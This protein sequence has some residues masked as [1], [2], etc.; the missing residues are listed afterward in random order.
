MFCSGNEAETPL[1]AG[2][3][4]KESKQYAGR[5]YYYNTGT[6]ET[7]WER[8]CAFDPNQM[9]RIEITYDRKFGKFDPQKLCA[10]LLAV[11]SD[12][13]SAVGVAGMIAKDGK[14]VIKGPM[15]QA[16]KLVKPL[17]S[18]PSLTVVCTPPIPDAAMGIAPAPAPRPAPAPAPA[19]APPPLPAPPPAPVPGPAP[20]PVEQPAAPAEGGFGFAA[21]A[22]AAAGGMEMPMPPMDAMPDFGNMDSM[23]MDFMA[24]MDAMN[25]PQAVE[26]DAS[27]IAPSPR[28]ASP[29][30]DMSADGDTP[31]SG[32]RRGGKKKKKKTTPAAAPAAPAPVAPEAAGGG[33]D[34]VGGQAD[35]GGSP[36]ASADVDGGGFGF[37]AGEAEAAEPAGFGFV[38]PGAEPEEV[39]AGGFDF[40]AGAAAAAEPQG[41]MYDEPAG[42]G[43][44]G[45]GAGGESMYDAPEGGGGLYDAPPG[46][47]ASM[48]DDPS[49]GG[50]SMYDDPSSGGGASMYDDPSA[51]GASMYDDP[52]GG[53]ASMYDDPSAGGASMYD[54]PSG[55]GE[56]APGGF[57]F[58]GGQGGAEP[59]AAAPPAGPMVVPAPVTG[60]ITADLDALQ[61]EEGKI[62]QVQVESLQTCAD[63]GT[64]IAA[65]KSDV[66]ALEAQVNDAGAREDYDEAEG[67]QGEVDKKQSSCADQQVELSAAD[68]RFAQASEAYSQVVERQIK[69]REEAIGQLQ[70]QRADQEGMCQAFVE[71]HGP[72]LKEEESSIENLRQAI[73]GSHQQVAADTETVSANACITSHRPLAFMVP[74]AES[75][76]NQTHCV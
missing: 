30:E 52:S 74:I 69:L 54:D 13:Q 42:A 36:A 73:A 25:S 38:Q 19:P 71:E 40:V 57:D 23:G 12:K 14:A 50:A 48:Y 11:G 45:D 41:S 7:V 4:A 63:V 70:E 28:D 5:F 2:W 76:V 24:G 31:S 3:E 72:K 27:E 17:A 51:G 49:G 1:P 9:A 59:P 15:S 43:I 65:L 33:F 39:A 58:M 64:S 29:A 18:I 37:I 10:Q 67:L 22:G 68:A 61:A 55:G 6:G 20:A 21:P 46:G 34:F 62:R 8:P 44:Y 56:A 16:A 47:G 66:E 53:G 35:A 32:I 60:D 26:V 75:D